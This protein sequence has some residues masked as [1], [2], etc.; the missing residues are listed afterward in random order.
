MVKPTG[1]SSAVFATASGRR[2]TLGLGIRREHE[3]TI[4]PRFG[5]LGHPVNIH[6]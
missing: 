5:A 4:Y 6:S 1:T 2:L 3:N